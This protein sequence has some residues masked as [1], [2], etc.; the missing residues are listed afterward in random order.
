MFTP[1]ERESCKKETRGGMGEAKEQCR[2]LGGNGAERASDKSGHQ[3]Q[4]VV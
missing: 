2:N 1:S 4:L 3:G